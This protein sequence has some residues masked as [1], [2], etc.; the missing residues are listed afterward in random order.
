MTAR[1]AANQT[2]EEAIKYHITPKFVV[3]SYICQKRFVSDSATRGDMPLRTSRKN[4]IAI[5]ASKV[6]ATG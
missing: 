4:N 3:C 6:V 2:V 1:I 5:L